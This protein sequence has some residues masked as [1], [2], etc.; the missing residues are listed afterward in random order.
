MS[1]DS[2]IVDIQAVGSIS[3]VHRIFQRVITDSFHH[4]AFITPTSVLVLHHRLDKIL[5]PLVKQLTLRIFRTAYR[6]VSHHLRVNE[7]HTSPSYSTFSFHLVS[8][9]KE[10]TEKQTM[11]KILRHLFYMHFHIHFDH[12]PLRVGLCIVQSCDDRCHELYPLG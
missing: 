3:D 6:H 5:D 7:Y 8:I 10:F 12:F 9:A 2:H 4:N 1:V 11:C